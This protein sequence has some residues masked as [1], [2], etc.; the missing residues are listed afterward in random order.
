MQQEVDP[1]HYPDMPAEDYHSGPGT[2][3]SQLDKIAESPLTYWSSYLDPERPE[4]KQTDAMVF[5]S[6]VHVAVLEPDL[7]TQK[8]VVEP[9]F[10]RRT[11]KGRA[12]ASAFAEEH[13]AKIILSPE[14]HQ[15]MLKVRDAV[16]RDPAAR[17]LLTNGM[18]E[19]SLFARCPETGEL[20]KCR[21][22]WLTYA[23]GM[24]DVKT[25][26]DASGFGFGREASTYRYD[27]SAGWYTNIPRI[28]FGELPPFF[29]LLAVEPT[30]PFNVGVYEVEPP[31]RESGLQ[32]GMRD[33]RR[34]IQC[35]A[36]NRWPSYTD[37]AVQP[38]QFPAYAMFRED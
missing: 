7:I 20:I 5:G 29:V 35:R 1:G 17:A 13:K 19:Q 8:I 22:D 9:G 10:N 32:K 4:R 18:P 2:S 6:A 36:E 15:R 38:L 24:I 25:T 27:V 11:E 16:Y 26:K 23:G 12:E 37:G 30:Y 3:K 28:L 14:D 31:V 34:L 21:P 33:L